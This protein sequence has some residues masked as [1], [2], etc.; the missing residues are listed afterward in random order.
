MKTTPL[1]TLVALSLAATAFADNHSE[2]D[3]VSLFDGK[4]LEGWS[5][6]S[7]T[8][9]Y[10]VEDGAI[11]GTTSGDPENSFLATDRFYG[12]FELE[13]EIKTFEDRFNGGV[14][15]RSHAYPTYK[16]G[17]VHGYQVEVVTNGTAGFIYDE[18]R[19]GWLSKE[20]KDPEKNAAFKKNEWN[21]FR[22]V[23]EGDS[24][25]TWIN[26][27]PIADVTD[28]QAANGFIALQVH[29]ARN[30]PG[31]KIGWRNIRIREIGDGGGWSSLF[32]G[33]DL[34]GWKVSENPDSFSVQ[35][36]LL[37]AKGPRAHAFYEGPI[38]SHSF[39]NFEF[40]A[41]IRT[42]P[43]ANSGLYIHT[44]FQDKGWPAKG[45]ECQVNNSHKD[46]RR[47]GGLY[48]IEDVKEAP[49]KD[50]EWFEMHITVMGKDITIAVDGKETV[51][52]TEPENAERP[53]N[54]KGR[55]LDRG[56]LGIQAH[57]PGSEVHYKDLRVKVLPE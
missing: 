54:M 3:W 39:K 1:C 31:W 51:S 29:S 46:W 50:G 52:Y 8:A 25:K 17:A 48:A 44:E 19:S 15:I 45:Y 9:K 12:D 40:K 47:T 57:D 16:N 34:T 35:D 41:M 32:N 27:I 18:L 7:G 14:Q 4:S 2:K 36:G 38:H 5:Q 11:I 26:G 37:V 13:L 20:R 55:L 6:L 30:N 10:T 43:N 21:K 22:I 24:I 56:T 49:A 33:K 23:C 53:A 42:K 28:S